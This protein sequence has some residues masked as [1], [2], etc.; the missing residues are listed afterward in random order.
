VAFSLLGDK[1]GLSKGKV[2]R[3]KRVEGPIALDEDDWI[4]G[5]HYEVQKRRKAAAKKA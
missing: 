2:K 1:L 4:K 3:A 5:T